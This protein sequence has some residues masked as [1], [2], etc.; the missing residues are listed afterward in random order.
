VVFSWIVY[1]DKAT[2]DATN[3]KVMED[4]RLQDFDMTIFDGKRMILG[5]FVPF[6]GP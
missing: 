4:P 6:I 5:G 1:P 2:R 3:K